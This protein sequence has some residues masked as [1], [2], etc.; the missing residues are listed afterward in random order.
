MISYKAIASESKLE[1]YRPILSNFAN[2]GSSNRLADDLGLAGTAIYNS[3]VR[4]RIRIDNMN[5]EER[6]LIPSEFRGVPLELNDS[7]KTYINN[8]T[9]ETNFTT[10]LYHN[11]RILPEDNGEQ[12]FSDYY[13]QQ[14]QRNK[15]NLTQD[16]TNLCICHKCTQ[17]KNPVQMIKK[18]N[19]QIA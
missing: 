10:Y 17:D 6:S 8:L 11:V 14:E 9:V 12:F 2:C 5:G 13:I 7:F 4:E 18:F 19:H 3:G 15:E 16:S 1:T